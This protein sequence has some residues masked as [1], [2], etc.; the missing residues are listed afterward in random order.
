MA[1][2]SVARLKAGERGSPDRNLDRSFRIL[3]SYRNHDYLAGSSCSRRMR[4]LSAPATRLVIAWLCFALIL[5]PAASAR[6]YFESCLDRGA[7]GLRF[8]PTYF[9]AVFDTKNDSHELNTTVFGNVLG[10]E[11]IVNLTA[12]TDN[13]TTLVSKY[14]VLTYTPFEDNTNF[15]ES[16]VN[17]KCPVEPVLNLER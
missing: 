5:R 12:G 17:G 3:Q 6:I 11:R 9:D 13:I 8:A 2:R 1:N 4:K 15:C 16:V 14:R 7:R 10:G